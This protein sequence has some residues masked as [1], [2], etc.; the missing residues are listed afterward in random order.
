MSCLGPSMRSSIKPKLSQSASRVPEDT[1]ADNVLVGQVLA[2]GAHRDRL[3]YRSMRTIAALTPAVDEV[4]GYTRY[5][6]QGDVEEGDAI[7]EVV[8]RGGIAHDIPSRTESD[9]R[10]TGTKH[11]AAYE[12]IVTVGRGQRDG[13]NVIIVPEIKDQQITGITLLHARFKETL[14]E[15]TAKL[16]LTGYRNRLSAIVDAV[17]ETETEFDS[18]KLSKIPAVDLL[19]E[20]VWVL[21]EH[22]RTSPPN[23]AG[24]ANTR[25]GLQVVAR[26][27]PPRIR[28]TPVFTK[29]A[30]CVHRYVTPTNVG[31]QER[32][33]RNA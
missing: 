19:V 2:A 8:D 28:P 13:R 3:T 26:G 7:L 29:P 15:E 20:P 30:R 22:W 9:P 11:R 6:V 32:E 1:F 17:T 5:Q 24:L 18:S 33:L 10:L 4:L 21:A 14:D 27:A 31:A 25:I 23:A 12:R 16:V